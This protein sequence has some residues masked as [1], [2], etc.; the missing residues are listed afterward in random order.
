MSNHTTEI[1]IVE[2]TSNLHATIAEY[3]G[4][5]YTIYYTSDGEDCWR[6]LQSFESVSLVYDDLQLPVMNGMLLLQKTNEPDFERIDNSSAIM[7]IR[8]IDQML[9]GQVDVYSYEYMH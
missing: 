4:D 6:Q 3:L 8:Q 9:I 2:D 5:E 7:L 1:C